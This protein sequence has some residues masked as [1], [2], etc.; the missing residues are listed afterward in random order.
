[1]DTPS[2]TTRPNLDSKIFR[3]VS[4]IVIVIILYCST[5]YY[6]RSIAT[7]GHLSSSTIKCD[8]CRLSMIES[9]GWFCESDS[10]WQ[11][12]KLVHH[13]QDRRNNVTDSRFL[14]FQNNWE[15]TVHCEFEQ[16]IG[17]TGDGGKWICDIHRFQQMNET[18]T[19]VYS[20]G[21]NGD[22][23]FERGIKEK[24]PQAEIHTF[25]KGFFQCPDGVCLFHQAYLGNGKINGTKSLENITQELGHSKRDIHILK[26]DIE[27]HEFNLFEELFGSSAST[28][29]NRLYI[30]QILF[31]IH[32]GS[33]MNE[34]MSRRTHRLFSLFRANN[35]AIFHKEVNLDNP[36][37]VFEDMIDD[38]YLLMKIVLN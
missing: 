15:S 29:K 4:F 12:R 3:S 33:N 21:S 16:R 2:I 37:N 5:I 20:F 10:N 17:R 35:Y 38:N 23:S 27:G 9:D 34:Q 18:N 36:Q 32:L 7:P 22:F 11:R 30:R 6:K 25:D 14:F 24:L 26:V 8:Q 28:R 1:M 19:L 31:E 13:A